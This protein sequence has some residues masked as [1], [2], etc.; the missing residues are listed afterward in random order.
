M[1]VGRCKLTGEIGQL[2]KS[3]VLP[4]ALTKPLASGAPFAQAGRDYPPIKRW[5]S[6][7]DSSIVTRSGEDILEGYDTWAIEELRKRK[8]VWSSW[9]GADQLEVSDFECIPDSDHWGFRTI[10]DLDGG[11]LRLFFLSLL[12]RAAVSEMQEFKEV[13]LRASELRRLRRMLLDGDPTPLHRFPLSLTQISTRGPVHNLTPLAQRRPK[14]PLAPNGAAIPIFRFY[15]DGLIAHFHRES[16]PDEVSQLSGMLLGCDEKL[17]VSTVTY[18]GSWQRE[19][20]DELV[21]EAEKR[22]PER[23]DRIPGF[24]SE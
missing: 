3:H 16:S 21:R 10:T 6:W 4:K 5:D 12:W 23:L 14:N 8:L 17:M 13:T 18:E 15:F 9:D 24:G 11:R 7:Y 22:W 1:A 19:N 2:V 20:F